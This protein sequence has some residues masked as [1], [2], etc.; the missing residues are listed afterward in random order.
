VN[1]ITI[2][3][4]PPPYADAF[5]EPV[6]MMPGAD[7][8]TRPP[9]PFLLEVSIVPFTVMLPGDEGPPDEVKDVP[10]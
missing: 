10:P 9:L 2:P 6:L 8:L 3:A 1:N 7:N 5:I 4:L